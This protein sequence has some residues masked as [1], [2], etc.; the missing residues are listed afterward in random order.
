MM[1]KV[2]KAHKTDVCFL[3]DFCPR[4]GKAYDE[5]TGNFRGCVSL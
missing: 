2:S 1:I 3:V 5:H 4:T